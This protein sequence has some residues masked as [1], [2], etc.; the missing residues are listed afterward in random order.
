MK[1]MNN[2]GFTLIELLAVVVIM[3]I[4]LV[5]T[6]PSVI[7]SVN[8]AKAKQLKNAANTVQSWYEKQ[9]QLSA[10]SGD[11]DSSV[12]DPAYTAFP[13]K[14]WRSSTDGDRTNFFDNDP[15]GLK[16]LIAAGLSE[17]DKNIDLH[18]SRVWYSGTTK[19]ICVLLRA[20]Q[21]GDFYIANGT[22]NDNTKCSS[23][24]P[25]AS[26]CPTVTSG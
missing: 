12:V 6:I 24:C 13:E 22:A 18:N 1:K 17:P 5:I 21:N 9:S 3:G 19:K 25:N 2:K 23:G 26:P 11:L 15:A 7:D 4:V 20:A 14:E 8:S 10:L 16:A